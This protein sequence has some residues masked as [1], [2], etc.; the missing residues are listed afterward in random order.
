MIDEWARRTGQIVSA[1]SICLKGYLVQKFLDMKE[2]INNGNIAGCE[3]IIS[4][5]A[6]LDRKFMWKVIRS[7]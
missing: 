7:I 2:M 3:E 6:A 1:A 5:H 4:S